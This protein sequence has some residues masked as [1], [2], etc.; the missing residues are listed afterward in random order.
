MSSTRCATGVR[1]RP[2]VTMKEDTSSRRRATRLTEA[3]D[4]ARLTQ[5]WLDVYDRCAID[6]FDGPDPQPI[7]SDF[8]HGH[9]VETERVRPV[10]GARGEDAHERTLLTSRG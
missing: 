8:F 6:G 5:R 9:C 10:L 1:R 7:P 2:K 4:K 3:T